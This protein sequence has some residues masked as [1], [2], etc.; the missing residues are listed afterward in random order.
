[1][2]NITERADVMTM[3]RHVGSGMSSQKPTDR[4]THRRIAFRQNLDRKISILG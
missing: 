3:F 2:D 4:E 1:M